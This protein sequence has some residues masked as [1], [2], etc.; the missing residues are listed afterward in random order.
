MFSVA[1]LVLAVAR[2]TPNILTEGRRQREAEMVWRG[3]QY[4]RAIKLFYQKNHRI[5]TSIEE[6]TTSNLGVRFLRKAYKD[7]MNQ[8]DGSWR[9]IYLGPNGQLIG[10][11]RPNTVF[12]LGVPGGLQP[13]SAPSYSSSQSAAGSLG[14]QGDAHSLVGQ[15]WDTSFG[16]GS[17]GISSD[18]TPSVLESA[19]NSSQAGTEAQIIG[20]HIIG[21]G[22]KIDA[23]SILWLY[24]A[25]NYLQ[26][27]F[28]WDPSK[29]GMGVNPAMLVNTPAGDSAP[30][31][32]APNSGQTNG[33]RS[34][35]QPTP[36]PE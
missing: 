3:K 34:G 33:L 4:E 28:I 35:P 13:G 8:A 23:K 17:R 5:P 9:F 18:S 29:D 36:G 31:P 20:G 27:E 30:Q 1:L 19:A 32:Q 14:V 24:G 7:P 26:F 16:P 6:L 11:T 10:S 21:V 15:S 22:S 2:V 12:T 25:K